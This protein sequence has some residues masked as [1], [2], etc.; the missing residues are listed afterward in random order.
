[1]NRKRFWDKNWIICELRNEYGCWKNAAHIFRTIL[2]LGLF[3]TFWSFVDFW[4]QPILIPY[5]QK[6]SALLTLL[7]IMKISC[8]YTF[9]KISC[10]FTFLF[11]CFFRVIFRRNP[12]CCSWSTWFCW[13]IRFS[14]RR[15]LWRN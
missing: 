9:L 3:H 4:L 7:K 5:C 13:T 14:R 10:L 8:L 15:W 11:I 2:S 6:K 12:S 1:M